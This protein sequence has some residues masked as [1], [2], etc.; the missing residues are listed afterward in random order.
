MNKKIQNKHNTQ[1]EKSIDTI[2]NFTKFILTFGDHVFHPRINHDVGNPKTRQPK[3]NRT[4][5]NFTR[6]R[7]TE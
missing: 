7:T 2:F 5:T 1:I 4:S 6:P 3:T